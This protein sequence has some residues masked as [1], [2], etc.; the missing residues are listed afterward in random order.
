[1]TLKT[2]VSI[3]LLSIL[4]TICFGQLTE[5]EDGLY[6]D[7]NNHL[8]TGSYIEFYGNGNKRIEL[9]LING[10]KDKQVFLYFEDGTTNEIRSYKAGK[11]DGTWEMWNEKGVKVGVANYKD[12]LKD[13]EW[14]IWD[15]NGILR[16]SMLYNKGKKDGSWKM[17]NEKGEL[18][19]QIDYSK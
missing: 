11:K 6:Y 14:F 19:N 4:S 18:I 13:G 3:I 15:T 17:W 16:F 9:N 2:F 5:S 12:N 7:E 1:M 8:Y 10:L